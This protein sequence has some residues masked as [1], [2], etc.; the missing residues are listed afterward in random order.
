VPGD[1]ALVG[2]DDLP[3]AGFA[4]PPLT[5][6]HQP[7]LEL[8]AKSVD[9]LIERIKEPARPPIQ[10]RLPARLVVRKSCGAI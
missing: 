4:D 10:M 9:I 5:T 8:G 3:V 1:I 7:V 6:V 2:F